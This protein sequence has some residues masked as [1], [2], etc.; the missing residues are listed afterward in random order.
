MFTLAHLSDPHLAPIPAPRLAELAGKRVTGYVNWQRNRHTVHRT[1]VLDALLRDLS[2]QAPDHI[3]VTGDLVNISLAAEFSAARAWLERL[4][5]PHDITVIPGNHDAYVRAM[6]A[7]AERVWGDYMAGDSPAETGEDGAAPKFPFLRRRGPLVL[8]A[9]SSAVPSLPVMATGRLGAGQLARLAEFLE[10]LRHEDSFRVVLV[11]HPPRPTKWHKRLVDAAA[12]RAVLARHGAD[13]LLHGH[14]HV[15]SLVWLD[16]PEHPIPALGVPSASAR[17]ARHQ[18]AAYNL[19]RI[20]GAPGR[21][22]CEAISRGFRET[23]EA[24]VELERRTLI[25]GPQ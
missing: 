24:V 7:E 25:P 18:P 15:H 2:A 20:D 1:E 13:L 16:G 9:L 5:T 4:G 23:G 14:D 8:V 6:R 19:Y 11:H 12:L 3:A 10:Y 22:Q 21:W 17:G